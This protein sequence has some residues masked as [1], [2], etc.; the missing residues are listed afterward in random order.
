MPRRPPP[1][2]PRPPAFDGPRQA[3][4]EAEQALRDGAHAPGLAA[5]QLALAGLAEA[6]DTLSADRARAYTVHAQH[7]WRLGR[8]EDAAD[9]GQRALT[10]WRALDD[11]TQCCQAHS[12][13]ATA[14]TELG[15][16]EEALRHAKAAFDLARRR[17]L[18]A[19]ETL[20]LN[21][22]GICHER[23]GD[24]ETGEQY[25]MRSL[26]NAH[27][28]ADGE[29]ELMAL[30]NLIAVGIGGYHLL[31]QREESAAALQFL[32]RA[33][34]HAE[35]ATERVR[36]LTDRYRQVVVEGN[37]GEVLALLGEFDAAEA[38][39]SAVIDFARSHKYK[40][41]ELRTRYTLGQM[42]IAQGRVPDALT[43][44]HATLDEL[45]RNDQVATRMRVHRALY[46]AYKSQARY[47]LAL[48]HF[49]AYHTI[50]LQRASLQLRA[51]ARLM[52][53]RIDLE[54][55]LPSPPPEP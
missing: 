1:P 29:A 8:F 32:Q 43:E 44:L 54:H 9:S 19:Q 21:R 23:L 47:D 45:R 35:E 24:P 7:L 3:L 4:A 15:L 33:R 41:V 12:L 30:N 53:S 25:L 37:L 20:A 38:L 10:D 27:E 34:V 22:L 2:A 31:M 39:L 13:L 36:S 50:E 28:A 6:G 52:A 48:A 51:Q 42:R 26:H 17:D 55:A 5:A 46:S 49:E 11:A 18:P 14:F 16:H 40:A